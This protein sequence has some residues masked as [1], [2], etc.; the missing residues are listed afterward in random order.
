MCFVSRANASFITEYFFV[1]N[2]INGLNIRL[3]KM[4]LNLTS[5]ADT[6]ITRNWL[7]K[8]Q[9]YLR[10]VINSVLRIG[11][12]LVMLIGLAS[13]ALVKND[14][15]LAGSLVPEDETLSGGPPRDGISFIDHPKFLS[16]SKADYI[17]LVDRVLGIPPP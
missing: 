5:R 13:A 17:K 4:K 16:A 8:M 10:E 11:M 12:P 14:F 1:D 2:V 9:L 15:D 6:A 3:I 7:W